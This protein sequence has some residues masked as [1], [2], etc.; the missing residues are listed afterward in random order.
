MASVDRV[1]PPFSAQRYVVIWV[2]GMIPLILVILLLTQLGNGSSSNTTA[3][4]TPTVQAG[5]NFGGAV[6]GATAAPQPATGNNDT[7]APAPTTAA[8]PKQSLT[9]PGKYMTIDTVKGK[10]V[11]KLYTDPE[12]G[13]SKTI[14]NFEDKAKAGYFNGLAFHRV[15]DWVI[16]GGDPLSK[17]PASIQNGTAGTGGGTMPSEYNQIN[18]GPG[19]LGIARGGDPAINND[20]QFF[21][22]KSDASYLDGQYTNWGQ[23]VEGM[24][25]VNQIAIGDKINTIT[26]ED[27]SQ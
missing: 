27:R 3:Q 16:Q 15:E 25:V 20:S 17:D 12:A 10:I 6:G 24:D 8:A 18:F 14:A 4:S 13:V 26:I 21:I 23:V 2:L 5:E 9:G 19:A 1:L 11:C 22:T 7:A